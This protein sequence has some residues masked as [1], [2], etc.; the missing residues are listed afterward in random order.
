MPPELRNEI[1]QY[2]F[3]GDTIR[4]DLT[5]RDG[6]PN[7]FSL[8]RVC[9]Q[10][11]NETAAL[12]YK[13]NTIWFGQMA[14]NAKASMDRLPAAQRR[15]VTSIRFKLETYRDDCGGLRHGTAPFPAS[16]FPA[17][18]QIEVLVPDESILETFG[19]GYDDSEMEKL[20][21]RIHV[22]N[23]NVEVTF[24][25]CPEIVFLPDLYNKGE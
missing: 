23:P 20:K 12:P 22:G 16:K 18:R 10:I 2:V 8:L 11:Y 13:L 7:R 17:L 4:P 15:A 24:L 9:R 1:W 19:R 6:T 5:G 21:N 14:V 3:R 25:K